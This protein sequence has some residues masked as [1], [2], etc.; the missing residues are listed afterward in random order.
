MPV[1]TIIT[2]GTT[3]DCKK[4]IELTDGINAE[5]LLADK[6]Y[7]SDEIVQYAEKQGIIPVIPPRCNRKNQREYNK[8]L[9]KKRHKVENTFLK[10]KQWRAVATRYAKN[11]SSF[12]AIIHICCIMLWSKT[13]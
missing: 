10:M 12:N 11:L 2:D 9:Y 5:N 6:G 3:S 7:D 4:A 8:E 1:R 13:L